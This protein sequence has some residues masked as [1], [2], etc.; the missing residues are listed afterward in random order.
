MMK[1]CGQWDLTSIIYAKVP[2]AIYFLADSDQLSSFT[3]DVSVTFDSFLALSLVRI[4]I[5]YCFINDNFN[6][7]G[8]ILAMTWLISAWKVVFILYICSQSS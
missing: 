7:C 8:L 5:P 1:I 2:S 4:C 6:V 3:V